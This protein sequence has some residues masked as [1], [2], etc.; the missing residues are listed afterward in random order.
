MILYMYTITCSSK[1]QIFLHRF[2]AKKK[3]QIFDRLHYI[4]FNIVIA[5]FDF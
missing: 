5:T 4:L 2:P 3:T 1:I